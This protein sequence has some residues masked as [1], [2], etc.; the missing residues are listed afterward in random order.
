MLTKASFWTAFAVFFPA[1]TGIMAGANMSGELERP[2]RSIPRGTLWAIGLTFAVYAGVAWMLSRMGT[3]EELRANQTI[4][5]DVALWS[6]VVLGG[7]LAATFSSALSVIVGA[8]RILQALARRRIVPKGEWLAHISDRGEPLRALGAT[9]VIVGLGVAMRSL[10]QIAELITLFFLLTY[11]AINVT[12]LIQQGFRLSGFRPRFRVPLIV[13][14]VGTLGCIAAMFVIHVGFAFAAIVAV[15]GVHTALARR[16]PEGPFGQV[17]SGLMLD[18]AEWVVKRLGD[19]PRNRRN[20]WL[21]NLLVPVRDEHTARAAVPMLGAIAGRGG[22]ATMYGLAD[23]DNNV[24][25]LGDALAEV[26]DELE[27]LTAVRC[28]TQVIDEGPVESVS[29]TLSALRTALL[30]PNL[31]VLPV[32]TLD[33]APSPWIASTDA[34][35]EALDEL[36]HVAK[37]RNFGL[38][39]FGL[40]ERVR[41]SDEGPYSEICVAFD[42]DL[43]PSVFVDDTGASLLVISAW[44]MHRA[45]DV[46]VTFMACTVRE[47]ENEHERSEPLEA[48][49]LLD[50]LMDM[51]RIPGADGRVCYGDIKSCVDDMPADGLLLVALP[52]PVDLESLR[53]IHDS[54][55]CDVLFVCLSGEA[56]AAG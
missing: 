45:W 4:M 23:A 21:A 51:A 7:L 28:V 20:A 15:I 42:G 43:E 40:G 26:K 13:P 41:D 16:K 25:S 27:E 53:E 35:Q 54:A 55:H 31:L 6:P 32:S 46:D 22:S 14:L 52:T 44:K 5:I 19:V 8:P 38:A 24:E 10:N 3:M 2:D 1:V 17:R 56:E 36:T 47:D 12:L 18:L 34:P 33:E 39:L 9:A 49:H 50:D 37:E 29:R 48:R 11:G 30:S